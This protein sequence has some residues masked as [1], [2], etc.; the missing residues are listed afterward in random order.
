MKKIAIILGHPDQTSFCAGLAATYAQA[1]VAQ[2]HEVRW[3][4][5]GDMKFDPILR[6]GYRQRQPLEPDLVQAQDALLW[7]D[8]HVFVYPIWWGG[9]PALLKGFFDRVFLPG[10]AFAYRPKSAFWDK[11]LA[12]RSAQ[13]L[14]TLDT[15][16]WYFRWVYRMP[17]HHQMKRTILE[18]T[19]VKPVRLAQFGPIRG[20]SDK[21]R[22]QW[23][24]EVA[25]LARHIR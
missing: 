16:V 8:H 9:M 20:S 11:L 19:G 15:P 13:L 6:G 3:L 25:K 7:A 18:W 5:L 1:A 24:V 17:G 14:V 21:Q 22:G 10:F 23:H 4:K 12:G 2:G